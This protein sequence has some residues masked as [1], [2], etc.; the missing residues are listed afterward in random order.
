MNV[1]YIVNTFF[2][3]YGEVLGCVRS[4]EAENLLIFILKLTSEK[5]SKYHMILGVA[6]GL[7]NEDKIKYA[8]EKIEILV[9]E[10]QE[11]KV[12][13]D[14]MYNFETDTLK[15]YKSL[16]KKDEGVI[17]EFLKRGFL[18]RSR[19]KVIKDISASTDYF[20]RRFQSSNEII[21]RHNLGS[22]D[23]F[24]NLGVY[25]LKKRILKSTTTTDSLFGIWLVYVLTDNNAHAIKYIQTKTDPGLV[26]LFKQFVKN[27]GGSKWALASMKRSI[28]ISNL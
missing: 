10:E 12:L 18:T 24:Y 22:N 6:L 13:F 14:L 20:N 4:E 26:E 16:V 7:I 23:I 15:S 5:R 2:I 19:V 1:K 8:L 3:K 25:Y 27:Q 9:I 21:S 17:L 28:T 11:A